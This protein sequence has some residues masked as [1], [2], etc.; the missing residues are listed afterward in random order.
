VSN[1]GD[2]FKRSDFKYYQPDDLKDK[3]LRYYAAF[4][5][6]IGKKERNDYTVGIVVGVDIHD[7]IDVVDLIRGRWD[8]NDL[9]EQILDLYV[10]WKPSIV[11]LERGVIEMS[12][13]PF[14][15]KRI[16]ERKLWEIYIEELKPG[17]RDKEARARAIQGR[18]QQG[19]VFFPAGGHFTHTLMTEMLRFPSG[20]HDDQVD[21]MAWIGH[22]LAEFHGIMEKVE[23]KKS[24]RDKIE[25]LARGGSG[26]KKSVMAS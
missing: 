26:K 14:L 2:Y 10:K 6:A 13:G 7:D 22:M 9:V 18:M 12:I 19:K 25:K 4:D 21:A 5:F 17:R 23:K 24:W 15:D 20:E 1:E 3:N 8:S 11:G 16:A